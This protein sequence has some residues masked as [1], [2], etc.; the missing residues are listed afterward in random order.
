MT[1]N[2]PKSCG[3]IFQSGRKKQAAV[4]ISSEEKLKE[5]NQKIKESPLNLFEI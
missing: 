5:A 1:L 3:K 2:S 4:V